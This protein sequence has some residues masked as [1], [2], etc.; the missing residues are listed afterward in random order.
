MGSNSVVLSMKQSK[1]QK[2]AENMSYLNVKANKI[3]KFKTEG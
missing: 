3:K 1:S 2:K